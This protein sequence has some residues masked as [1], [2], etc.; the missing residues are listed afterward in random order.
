MSDLDLC[1]A[2]CKIAVFKL[3]QL[4]LELF[5]LGHALVLHRVHAVHVTVQG[6]HLCLFGIDIGL[7]LSHLLEQLCFLLVELLYNKIVNQIQRDD[8]ERFV[9]AI[10]SEAA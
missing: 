5:L 8:L 6:I 7:E 2:D 4:T 9:G 10:Y 1:L 3:P